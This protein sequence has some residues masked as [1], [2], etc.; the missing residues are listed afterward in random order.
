MGERELV[1][2]TYSRKDRAS[3][4]GWGCHPVVKTLTH[5][6]SCLKELHGWKWRGVWKKWSS[7]RPKVG[8]SSRRGPKALYYYWGYGASQKETYYDCL[9]L[10]DPTSSWKSQIQ[11]FAPNQWTEAADSCGWI[12]NQD[13]KVSIYSVVEYI[14]VDVNVFLHQNLRTFS[15]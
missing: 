4:D 14:H 1:E 2:P 9:P 5:N 11:I 6:C 7:D 13:I 15:V 12:R 10:K 3:S 8:S